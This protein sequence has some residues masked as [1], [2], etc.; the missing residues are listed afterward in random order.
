M[1]GKWTALLLMGLALLWQGLSFGL[2]SQIFPGPWETFRTLFEIIKDGEVALHLG[3]T[4]SRVGASFVGAMLLGTLFGVLMGFFPRLDRLFN[5]LLII[6]LNIPALVTMVVLYV[7]LG[8]NEWAAVLAVIFNK[9]P[10]VTVILREG[11]RSLDAKLFEMSHVF[12]ISKSDIFWKIT[13]PQLYP[14]LL[15]SAKSGLSL[16]WKIVLVVEFLGRGNGIGFQIHTFFQDFEMASILAYTILLIA[17]MLL[18]DYLIMKPLEKALF[19]WRT[20]YQEPPQF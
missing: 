5:P 12:R 15:S 11:T 10:I 1:D 7:A 6:G 17:V 8:L 19:A 3:A 4:L 16:I 2:T 20:P 18:I 13:L 9:I 14:Y